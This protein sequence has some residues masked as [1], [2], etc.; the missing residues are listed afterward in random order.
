MTPTLSLSIDLLK[1]PSVTPNDFDCQNILADFLT[2]LGFDCEFLYFGDPND[3]GDNAQIKNLY[4]KRKGTDPTAP[5]LCFAGHTDVV[6]VGDENLWTYPPFGATITDGYLWGRGASDMK[7]AIACFCVACDEFIKKHPN[8]KGDISLLITSD[9]EG[10]A[11]NGTKKVA[12]TLASRGERMDYCLVGEP[13]STSTLGDVIKNGRRGSLSGQLS[14][15]GKQGHIAYPHLAVN[16]IHEF[17]P[18]MNELVGT[19]WDNGNEYFPATSFQI[20]NINGGTGA[21]NVIPNSV[22]I[23]FNFRFCNE[24]TAQTLKAKTHDILDRHFAN[25]QATYEIKWSLSGEPFLTP[26][27]DFVDT[28]VSAIK[29]ITGTD[30]TLSTSG[31][32]SD[33]R[34]IAPIMSA[35]VVELG[36]LNDTI[37]QIDEKVKTDDLEQLTK[38]YETILINL[39][40]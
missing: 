27:G 26:K 9:E 34:F 17:A 37:H 33:G 6:P 1:Q 25:S 16:P 20:S 32:T 13:S 5:H 24:N 12:E 7:T 23:W 10:V 11:I 19:Q 8:H 22:D 14:I 21:G 2:K 18:A 38:I 15:T 35:Q 39:I 40:Q 31:G 3:T 36:V 4:A 28:V 30:S 29:E